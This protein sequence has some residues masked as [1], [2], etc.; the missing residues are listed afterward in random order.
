MEGRGKCRDRR[1][2]RCCQCNR[3]EDQLWATAYEYVWP[4]VRRALCGNA[5]ERARLVRD[6]TMEARRA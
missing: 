2:R 6:G 5:A 4:L 1:L 3:L